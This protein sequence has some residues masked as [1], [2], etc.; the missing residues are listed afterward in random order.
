MASSIDPLFGWL[1]AVSSDVIKAVTNKP[2]SPPVVAPQPPVQVQPLQNIQQ[3]EA[4]LKS[5]IPAFER[6]AAAYQARQSNLNA[7]IIRYNRGEQVKPRDAIGTTT[8]NAYFMLNQNRLNT[9]YDQLLKRENALRDSTNL[10]NK[11]V[12][13]YNAGIGTNQSDIEIPRT[14]RG[15]GEWAGNLPVGVGGILSFLDPKMVGI[16]LPSVAEYIDKSIPVSKMQRN[17]RGW[18]LS[19]IPGYFEKQV[20]VNEDKSL[21]NSPSIFDQQRK[22]FINSTYGKVLPD[23]SQVKYKPPA[24]LKQ[25]D[26]LYTILYGKNGLER[27]KADTANI[28]KVGSYAHDLTRDIYTYGRDKPDEILGAYVTGLG[29]SKA[30]GLLGKVGN[31]GRTA[32]VQNPASPQYAKAAV[33]GYDLFQSASKPIFGGMLVGGTAMDIMSDTSTKSVAPKI[34]NT[35]SLLGGMGITRRGNEPSSSYSSKGTPPGSGQGKG[36]LWGGYSN[37]IVRITPNKPSPYKPTIE[38]ARG[39]YND[40]LGKTAASEKTLKLKYD[41]ATTSEKIGNLQNELT[42]KNISSTEQA[43]IQKNISELNTYR[44][45]LKTEYRTY[46][47]TSTP[48]IKPTIRQTTTKTTQS[49]YNVL[50][51]KTATSEKTLKL[52]YDIATTSEKIGNL[53]NEL[54]RKNISSTEQA[55]IQKNISE[56]NWR[57]DNAEKNKAT[58]N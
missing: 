6:D 46:A 55:L 7:D 50:F 49:A 32:V 1:G 2:T 30:F 42:R 28:N 47:G 43:L 13:D 5:T 40:I 3:Q 44:N 16:Q 26:P 41:I 12:K 18:S 45:T 34:I 52:K 22:S 11:S 39:V 4:V 53:Q 21:I 10:Y 56:L 9:E 31:I 14:T 8:N 38:T 27:Q 17:E 20:Y 58:Y 51:G 24:E 48:K 57:T 23:F 36:G 15:T 54:T 37:N 25:A 33:K 35:I 19:N 29:I